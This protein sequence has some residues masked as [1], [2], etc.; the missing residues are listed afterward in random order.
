MWYHMVKVFIIAVNPFTDL[1]YSNCK[2][3]MSFIFVFFNICVLEVKKGTKS[4]ECRK[5][6]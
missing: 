1:F 6:D 4:G 3:S 5:Y 2:I